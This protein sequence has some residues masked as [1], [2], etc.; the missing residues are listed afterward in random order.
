MIGRRRRQPFKERRKD[1]TT[2][3]SGEVQSQLQNVGGSCHSRHNARTSAMRDN[4]VI[5]QKR[6]DVGS[7][8]G[9]DVHPILGR[10]RAAND[11]Y[12]PG[13]DVHLADGR[14]RAANDGYE[15]GADIGSFT[16]H[17]TAANDGYEPNPEVPKSC[18]VCPQKISRCVA[19]ESRAATRR[20]HRTFDQAA[21]NFLTAMPRSRTFQTFAPSA[22][23]HPI[24]LNRHRARVVWNSV[25][26]SR[27]CKSRSPA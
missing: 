15:P 16:Y 3:F 10:C 22:P 20:E 5:R 26:H 17:A 7:E 18:C 6:S 1:S 13:A 4:A 27:T 2:F 14:C 23:I 25:T 21:A 12:E 24:G 8:P 19:A 9:T 11:G